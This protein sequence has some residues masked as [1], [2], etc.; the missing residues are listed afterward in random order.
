MERTASQA[1]VAYRFKQGK[2][3]QQTSSRCPENGASGGVS[4]MRTC[5]ITLAIVSAVCNGR[6]E[7]AQQTARENARRVGVNQKP[8]AC[9]PNL[10][11]AAGR[12]TVTSVT[13]RRGR[14][15]R[16]IRRLTEKS[17]RAPTCVPQTGYILQRGSVASYAIRAVRV[18]VS[19]CV[20]ANVPNH[21]H[22]YMS[23]EGEVEERNVQPHRA[24]SGDGRMPHR[25]RMDCSEG[26][27]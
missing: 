20:C 15:R 7:Y 25:R 17:S 24:A 10:R 27:W 22:V 19:S 14:R 23:A 3:E 2:R 6:R 5:R 26:A 18:R 1:L 4:V 9:R 13:T 11:S 21:V 12:Q 16:T 8:S